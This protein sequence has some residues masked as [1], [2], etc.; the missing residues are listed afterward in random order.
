M[1]KV[2]GRIGGALTMAVA[3]GVA[4]TAAL[5]DAGV[6]IALGAAAFIAFSM[7]G[8]KRG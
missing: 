7:T 8:A 1:G 6:G 4:M 2:C 3:V 5:D